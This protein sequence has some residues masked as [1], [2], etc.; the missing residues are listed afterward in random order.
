MLGID[1]DC[2]S[3][4]KSWSCC[5]KDERPWSQSLLR[6]FDHWFPIEIRGPVHQ[7]EGPKQHWE[8]YSGHL[9]N[10]AHAV[11]CLFGVGSLGFR[12]FELHSCAVWNGW[13]GRVLCEVGCIIHTSWTGVVWLFWQSQWVL[14]L[15]NREKYKPTLYIY[16]YIYVAGGTNYFAD[17]LP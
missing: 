10:L 13:D 15:W 8:H 7:V 12:G 5:Q 17:V 4:K 9:V 6:P 1:F 11:V 2:T 14:L 16:I 3:V